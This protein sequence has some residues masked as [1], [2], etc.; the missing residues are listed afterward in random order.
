MLM[1]LV[2]LL[3]PVLSTLDDDAW[4]EN[5]EVLEL[6][7]MN[8]PKGPCPFGFFLLKTVYVVC[9]KRISAKDKHKIQRWGRRRTKNKYPFE[10][11]P[12]SEAD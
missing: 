12:Q 5:D 8:E 7:R 6:L 9:I 10:I 11:N 1:L 4:L 2:L 3:F